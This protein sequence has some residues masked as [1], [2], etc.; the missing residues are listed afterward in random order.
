VRAQQP[1]TVRRIGALIALAENDSEGKAWVAG[2]RQGLEKRGWYGNGQALAY[3]YFEDEPGRRVA[4]DHGH[5]AK[6]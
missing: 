5:I 6:L 3:V 1:G 4:A 2:F